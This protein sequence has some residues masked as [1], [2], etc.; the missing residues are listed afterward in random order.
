MYP[1]QQEALFNDSRY[2][3][4]EASTKSG[5]TVSAIAWIVEQ[6]V[7]NGAPGRQFWWAAPIYPQAHIA[8]DRMK[9]GLPKRL[10]KY[11]E[12]RQEITLKNGAII[13]FKGSDKPDSLYGE[14]VYAAVVDEASRCKEEAWH[15]I[16][17]TLTATRGP[18]RIIG[19]VKGKKNWAYRMARRAEAGAPGYSWHRITAAD[20]VA[21]GVLEQEEIDDARLS[22]PEHVFRELYEAFPSDDDSNPFGLQPIRSNIGDLSDDPAVVWGIDLAK[23]VDWTVIIGLDRNGRTARFLRF[24]KPWAETMQIIKREVTSGIVLIDSTGVGDAI[25]EQV[26]RDAGL[27]KVSGYLFTQQSKQ[28]LMEGL[29]LAIQQGDTSYP[30]GPIVTELEEFEYEYTKLGVRYSAPE[31]AHDDCVCALALAVHSL[32][33]AGSILEERKI[34]ICSKCKNPYYN[35]NGDRPC[36]KCGNRP[37]VE[38]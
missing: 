36:T 12:T 10:Y 2:S 21:A 25:V 37:G 18:V 3:V 23:S 16:R 20:A 4:I 32:P 31:G 11:N 19:N 26:Q 14:D 34:T 38:N 33:K 28:K 35:P 22:L 15:A 27:A 9:R 13:A 5:K 1:K 6:A 30:E 7:L 24:Q 17:S 29:S 8:Y